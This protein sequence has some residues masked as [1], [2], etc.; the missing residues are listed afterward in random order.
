MS[1]AFSALAAKKNDS[2]GVQNQ[3]QSPHMVLEKWNPA[4]NGLLDTAVASTLKLE[5]TLNKK[6]KQLSPA[7]FNEKIQ[8]E[9]MVVQLNA[10]VCAV[11]SD[12]RLAASIEKAFLQ[13]YAQRVQKN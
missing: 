6:K 10:W 13:E 12:Q 4:C 9:L 3:S 2:A 1:F 5:K 8:N 11:S 7:K